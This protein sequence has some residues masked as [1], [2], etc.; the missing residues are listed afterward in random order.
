MGEIVSFNE[1]KEEQKLKPKQTML[2][3]EFKKEKDKDE[4]DYT[5]LQLL[6]LFCQ[7]YQPDIYW[8]FDLFIKEY[9]SKK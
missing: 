4:A 1:F 8:R 7:K 5:F 3:E 9:W 6:D 2:I